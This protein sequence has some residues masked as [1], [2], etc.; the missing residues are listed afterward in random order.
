MDEKNLTYIFAERFYQVQQLYEASAKEL[1]GIIGLKASYI[2]A[3]EN[4]RSGASIRMILSAAQ[5]LGLSIDWLMD[6]SPLPYTEETVKTAEELLAKKIKD[7]ALKNPNYEKYLVIKSGNIVQE[8][9]ALSL[10]N[11]F[12]LLFLHQFMLGQIA[13]K[14]GSKQPKYNKN[15]IRNGRIALFRSYVMNVPLIG[16]VEELI[17]TMKTVASNPEVPVWDLKKLVTKAEEKEE[18][19][20]PSMESYETSLFDI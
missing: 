2:T 6:I 3:V 11:R 16:R 7:L 10:A 1:E 8:W 13:L 20:A 15:T 9:Q 17:Q 18:P 4:H 5:T 19:P 14:L 12:N